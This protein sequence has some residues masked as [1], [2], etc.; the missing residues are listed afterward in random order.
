MM[1]ELQELRKK[2]EERDYQGVLV[3][4]NE[5]EEMSFSYF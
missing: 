1:N 2:I 4:V 5:L 3:I